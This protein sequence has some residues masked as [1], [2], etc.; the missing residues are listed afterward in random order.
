MKRLYILFVIIVLIGSQSFSQLNP[1]NALLHEHTYSYPNNCFNLSWS[2]PDYTPDTL[3]GYNVYRDTTLYMFTNDM[4]FECNPCFGMPYN[5][6]CD[7]I[8]FNGGGFTI[9]VKAVYNV[10]MQESPGVSVNCFGVAINVDEILSDEINIY[11][12]PTKG[13]LIIQNEKF[14]IYNIEVFD[15]YGKE[16]GSQ[17][18]EAGIQKTEID[19]STKAKGIYIIKVQTDKG[20]FLDKIII[21]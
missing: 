16:G 3:K 2:P 12:N 19:L 21:E 6:F 20:I 11:P 14:R 18:T 8:D 5:S 10:A 15:I 13:Q 7:F 1:V 9:T 4:S 17:K